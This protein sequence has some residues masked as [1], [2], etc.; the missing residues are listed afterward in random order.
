V[1]KQDTH[2]F[3]VFSLVLGI[4][5]VIAILLFALS[6]VIGAS[7]GEH[8]KSDALSS[9]AVQERT[10]P[11][12]RVAVAGQDNAA[13]TIAGPATSAASATGSA[14]G[15][16]SAAP[17]LAG[18]EDV[19]KSACTACHAMGIAGAPKFGDK[20]LWA[21]RIAQGMDTLYK[22]SI[23]GFQGSTGIMPPKGGRMDISD[24]LIRASVDYMVEGSR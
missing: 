9:A 2:F 7:Q 15:S 5:V 8:L 13:L 18:G 22:H 14:T 17:A 24:E 3:N 21:P 12:G 1:S 10:R 11:V 4:L 16:A 20:A 6:R 23:E 19:Y